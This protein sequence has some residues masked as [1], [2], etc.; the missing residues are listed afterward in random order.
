MLSRL[1]AVS[2][3]AALF[4]IVACGSS[5]EGDLYEKG[6]SGG[7]DASLGGS[8]GASGASA[9]TGGSAGTSGSAGQD[10]GVTGGSAGVGGAVVDSGTDA[11]PDASGG[12]SGVGTGKCG[13]MTCAFVAEDYC[14]LPSSGAP[15]CANDNV[16]NSCE[17]SGVLCN[18]V[19]IH[20]DG[21]EDCD[22]GE[23]CCADTG[24]TG[25]AYNFVECRQTCEQPFPVGG[26]QWEVCHPGGA[27]CKKGS[28]A[29]DP[30]LPAGYATC[31]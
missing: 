18:T 11:P 31:K 7:K 13:S 14:C 24:F 4:V 27:A 2:S 21:P 20:C 12:T 28:C 5:S 29:P 26:P 23:I 22:G 3:F 10:S 8:A 6:G 30:G 16:G 25:G 19:D 17:C 9:G 15:Y 1:A